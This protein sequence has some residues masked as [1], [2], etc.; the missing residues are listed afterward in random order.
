[1]AYTEKFSGEIAYVKQEGVLNHNDHYLFPTWRMMNVRC[2]DARH[3]AYHR[4]GG[5]G[6]QVCAEWRWD[7]PIAFANFLKNM[8]ERP[9]GTT[10]DRTDNDCDYSA[11]NCEWRSKR[12]Q[13]N[14]IGLG[15]HNNSGAMGV[16]WN[17]QANAWMAQ[18]TLN[19]STKLISTYNEENFDKARNDYE[20]IKNIKM[21]SG[22]GAALEAINGLKTLTPKGKNLRRNKTSSFYGVSYRD[23]PKPWRALCNYRGPD[24]KL[25]QITL[26][27]FITEEEAAKAVEDYLNEN[28]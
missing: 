27:S 13:Q 20:S 10:L 17:S 22:D 18:I 7:N 3:K 12:D 1:M 23:R 25:R 2:Y 26:G 21:A 16:S 6:V 8:G 28:Q 15:T 4:Y 14:N 24:G 9:T 5:R 19:G 11:M